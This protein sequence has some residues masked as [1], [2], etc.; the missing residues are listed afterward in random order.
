MNNIHL[1][2]V[3]SSG[4]AKRAKGLPLVSFLVGWL[5]GLV[6]VLNG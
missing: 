4:M 5:V 6:F 3:L 2:L 1:I